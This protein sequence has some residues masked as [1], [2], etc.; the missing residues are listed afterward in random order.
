MESSNQEIIINGRFLTQSITGVQRYARELISAFDCILDEIPSITV[1]IVTPKKLTEFP[2]YRNIKVKTVC[3]FSGHFWEQFILPFHIKRDSILFCP[4]NSAPIISIFTRNV[5][6][7]IHDLSFKYFPSAYSTLYKGFYNIV[8]PLILRYA[9]KIITVSNSELNSIIK[10]YPFVTDRIFAI[11]NGATP[12]LHRPPP[13]NPIYSRKL[14]S[15][16][17]VGSLSKRKNID[18][19][20]KIAEILSAQKIEFIFIGGISSSLQ[21]SINFTTSLDNKYIKFVGHI[22]NW[23]ILSKYY[24]EATCFLFPSFY[25]ASP[26]PPIEAMSCGCPVIASSIPS[27]IERCEDSALYCEPHDILQIINTI[28]RLI[29]DTTLQNLIRSKGFDQSSKFTWQKCAINTLNILLT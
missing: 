13:N 23:E 21:S 17:Y 29:N 9:K 28:N 4:C 3:G 27:L 22:E 7:T 2:A 25:E 15:V 8:T 1:T 16:L 11:Q 14:N 18:G 12:I 19:M 20:L 26:L 6:V 24:H 10:L 5:I